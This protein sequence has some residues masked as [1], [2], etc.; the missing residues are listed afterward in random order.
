MLVVDI[1]RANN[2]WLRD[3]PD[4]FARICGYFDSRNLSVLDAKIHTTD[5]G[6]ALD[7]FVVVDPLGQVEHYRNILPMVE[8]ELTQRLAAR[9]ELAPPVR[10][11]VSRRSR[12]FPIEPS[13]DLRPDEGGQRYLL[14][15]V[16]NEARNTVRAAVRRTTLA[17]REAAFAEA[18][19][20][21]PESADPAVATTP[22]KTN[23][24][25]SPSPA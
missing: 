16:A 10:G 6:R 20:V 1:D 23:T 3:Q 17:D 15:I 8:S 7:S 9:T 24:N 2:P 13:V 5:D 18:E 4:L 19:P 14:S 12:H 25:T 21:I 11:R 22:K